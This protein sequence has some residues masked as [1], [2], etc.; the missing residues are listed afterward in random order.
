MNLPLLQKMRNVLTSYAAINFSRRSLLH[1]ISSL[2]I[3]TRMI[4]RVLHFTKLVSPYELHNLYSSPSISRMFKSRRMRWAGHVARI[5]EK[6]NAYR[7]LLGKP[8]GKR[9]LGRP[10]RRLVDNIK[11]DLREI[12]W[13]GM[14]WFNL[15][16]DRDQWRALVNTVM[17]LRV[18]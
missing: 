14:D 5:G 7:I 17:H 13:D 12:G 15:A 11:M 16:Q 18:P 2:I 6:M 1:G 9:P 3:S 4:L 8:E 10:R